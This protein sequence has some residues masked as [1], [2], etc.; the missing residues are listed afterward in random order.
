MSTSGTSV[1]EPQVVGQPDDWPTTGSEGMR[2][3]RGGDALDD[4]M[5]D[6]P[7]EALGDDDVKWGKAVGLVS[8]MDLV[9]SAVIITV[10]F[11]YAYK[12]NGVSLFCMGF[13]AVSHWLSSLLLVCRSV[14]EL[15]TRRKGDNTEYSLIE[16]RRSQLK[17][18]QG[19]SITMGLVMLISA[20]S[21]LFK[22]FRKLR[23]WNRWYRDHVD[24]DDEA[25]AVSEWLAWSGFSIYFLQA[26]LRC[27]VACK[28]KIPVFTHACVASFVSFIFLL[29]LGL[30]ASYEKE[31]S[32]KAEPIAA[33][34][35]SV[36]M[37][38]EG[39]R[40]VIT[41]LDD[42]DMRLQYDARA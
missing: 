14:A 3:R 20:C 2:R 16:K 31:W 9:A 15:C 26:I 19:I 21:L 30:A 17:L 35:L 36:A 11:K 33:C 41:Y 38:V 1:V 28:L 4:V 24:M 10:S 13:Q 34:V 39:V 5:P 7:Q 29:A 23:F 12:D 42:M 40:V 8:G 37:V 22:A 27:V 18:E 6:M 25:Q 32:W